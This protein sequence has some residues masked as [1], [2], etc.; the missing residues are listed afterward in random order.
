MR[1]ALVRDARPAEPADTDEAL[2]ELVEACGR[3]VLDVRGAHDVL[4]PVDP[5]VAEMPVVLGAGVVEVRQVAAV[6]DDA[7]RVGIRE[8][9]ARQSGV[10][11]RRPLAGRPPELRNR[12]AAQTGPPVSSVSCSLTWS[13]FARMSVIPNPSSRAVCSSRYACAESSFSNR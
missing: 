7:L 5:H 1:G 4:G 11:E 13:S 9:D 2:E 6:V 3:V 10:L 12:L 8:P